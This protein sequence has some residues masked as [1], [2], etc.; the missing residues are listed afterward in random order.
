MYYISKQDWARLEAEH[1]DYVG[2]SI[3]DR[4]I[5]VIMEGAIPGNNG[6]GG[7]TLLFE[8]KHF[9]VVDTTRLT[10]EKAI[11][12]QLREEYPP[13]TRVVLERMDDVQAPPIGTTGTV[14]GVDSAGSLLMSWDSGGSLSVVLGIDRVTKI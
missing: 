8:H 5:R 3:N 11:L 13:G 4:N 12:E 9:E 7:T 14:Q 2:R 10:P 6:K 1:S